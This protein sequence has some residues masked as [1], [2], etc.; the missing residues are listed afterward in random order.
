MT[1]GLLVAQADLI[2]LYKAC[3]STWQLNLSINTGEE[4]HVTQNQTQH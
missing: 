4:A 2:R 1:E 3:V